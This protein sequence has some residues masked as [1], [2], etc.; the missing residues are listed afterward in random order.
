MHARRTL[1]PWLTARLSLVLLILGATS[2]AIGPNSNEAHADACTL[3]VVY[4][5]Y[6]YHGTTGAPAALDTLCFPAVCGEICDTA[7]WR[8]GPCAYAD[9]V[10]RFEFTDTILA[11]RMGE[12][13]G[14][15]GG[16]DCRIGYSACRTPK[17]V[18]VSMWDGADFPCPP[19]YKIESAYEA[20]YDVDRYSMQTNTTLPIPQTPVAS[21]PEYYAGESDYVFHWYEAEPP[22]FFE[23]EIDAEAPYDFHGALWKDTAITVS[24]LLIRNVPSV[25]QWRVRA[26][27]RCG[28]SAWSTPQIF[29]GVADDEVGGAASPEAEAHARNFPNPFN[30][31]AVIEFDLDVISDW[32]LTIYNILGQNIRCYSG[33]QA[34]G[35][36][37]VEWYGDDGVGNPMPSGMYFYRVET[38]LWSESRKMILLR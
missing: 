8:C 4:S 31:N 29:A 35:T 22:Q 16:N 32:S 11:L 24:G 3:V 20:S 12:V 23:L 6:L 19:P 5:G 14:G 34:E 26:G 7:P 18:L 36:Q 15:L 28:V 1:V 37:V 13:A 9:E 25:I 38:S 2:F 21:I 30:A 17:C 27:N 10:G 33:T